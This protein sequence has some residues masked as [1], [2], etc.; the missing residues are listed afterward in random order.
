ML[1]LWIWMEKTSKK[2][3]KAVNIFNKKFSSDMFDKVLNTFL[4]SN[5]TFSSAMPQNG[6]THFKNLAADGVWQ[7]KFVWSFRDVMQ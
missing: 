5:L 4:E 3:V 1:M 7:Q 2:R 6:Q